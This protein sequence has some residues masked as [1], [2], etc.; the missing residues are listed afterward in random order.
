M[1]PFTERCPTELLAAILSSCESLGDVRALILTC[2]RI[3]AVWLA[4]AP[5]IIA[6]IGPRVV[7]EFDTVLMAVS[8]PALSLYHRSPIDHVGPCH[9]NRAQSRTGRRASSS[10]RSKNPISLLPPAHASGAWGGG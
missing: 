9:R 1:T 6:T 3:H 2:R 4:Q 8:L 7:V 10:H 5:L